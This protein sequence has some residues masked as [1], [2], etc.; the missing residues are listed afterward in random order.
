MNVLTMNCHL[1]YQPPYKIDIISIS[2]NILSM[3][4]KSWSNL[5]MIN[6][7]KVREL[8]WWSSQKDKA[9]YT[10]LDLEDNSGPVK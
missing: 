8:V 5:N 4:S 6:F 7:Y 9:K 2:S 3:K 10:H 1:S